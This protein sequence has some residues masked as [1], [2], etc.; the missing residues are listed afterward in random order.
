MLGCIYSSVDATIS[1]LEDHTSM[2]IFFYSL[3]HF[4]LL[5]LDI[6]ALLF[7]PFKQRP[8]Y[9]NFENKLI[10]L[11]LIRPYILGI[12]SWL[13]QVNSSNFPYSSVCF[14]FSNIVMIYKMS[15]S[16]FIRKMKKFININHS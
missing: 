11:L 1:H 15:L 6:L 9:L 13:N 7:Q 4:L 2:F 8:L 10:C 14:F 3:V 12:G 16:S 5:E